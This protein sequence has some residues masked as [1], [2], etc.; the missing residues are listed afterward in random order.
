MKKPL[1]TIIVLLIWVFFFHLNTHAQTNF[2]A[3]GWYTLSLNAGTAFQQSDIPVWWRGYG[4]GLTLA[5]NSYYKP[6]AFLSL[7][8]RGRLLYA[9]TYGIDTEPFS[10]YLNNDAL[11]GTRPFSLDLVSLGS[12][13][14]YQN[15]RTEH[16]ELAAEAVGT[17]NRWREKTGIVISPF[18]GLGAQ[19]HKP[20]IDQ[21]TT[22]L[23]AYENIDPSSS[24]SSIRKTIRKDIINGNF[25]LD[26]DEFG[27]G[28]GKW[29]IM[30]SIGLELGYHLRSNF[31]LSLNHRVTFS[32]TDLLDGA[33][34]D[35]ANQ[36]T[37]NNDILHYTSIGFNWIIQAEEALTRVPVIELIQPSSTPSYCINDQFNFELIANLKNILR[38]SDIL[39]TLNSSIISFQFKNGRLSADLA[40][41]EGENEVWISVQNESGKKD[42]RL[43]IICGDDLPITPPV[44]NK[45]VVSIKF[46]DNPSAPSEEGVCTTSINAVV[47]GVVSAKDVELKVNN[48]IIEEFNFFP[49]LDRLVADIPLKG[50]LNRIVLTG[51]N[52]YGSDSDQ[53][54]VFCEE[55]PLPSPPVITITS[56]SQPSVN[57]NVPNVRISK[58]VAGIQNIEKKSQISFLV[59]QNPVDFTFDLNTG[60]FRGTASL[61]AGLNEIIIIAENRGGQTQEK[62]ELNI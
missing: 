9:N 7:D 3:P 18:A 46:I 36:A 13:I 42:R 10:G 28:S 39:I 22:Y 50:G 34:W 35:N 32:N 4:L 8:V 6:N 14:I 43:V 56:V 15:H 11:N 23:E 51:S 41:Q 37:G 52:V 61:Q 16:F 2:S 60:E 47:S 38:S 12:P 45:P 53:A 29:N 33:R 40:L 49:I 54:N 24:T 21:S 25:N 48:T 26:A 30:P 44:S 57:P 58:I 55:I 59:N 1:S 17:L 20:S 62:I 27:N 19:W 5:K 31:F